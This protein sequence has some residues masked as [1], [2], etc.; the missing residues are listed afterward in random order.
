MPSKL[1]GKGP[2]KGRA[3]FKGKIKMAAKGKKFVAL[4][5]K[6]PK[7]PGMQT[8]RVRGGSEPRPMMPPVKS[9]SSAAPYKRKIAPAK[10]SK[11]K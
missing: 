8:D 10:P 6:Q 5:S 7:K 4:K 3:P 9:K 1:V 2:L 11:S